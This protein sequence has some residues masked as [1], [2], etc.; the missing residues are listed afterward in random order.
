VPGG[1]TTVPSTRPASIRTALADDHAVPVA[2]LALLLGVL[3]VEA[4]RRKMRQA[5][6]A[7]STLPQPEGPG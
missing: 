2:L 6:V 1:A 5:G 3:L 7:V 4:D